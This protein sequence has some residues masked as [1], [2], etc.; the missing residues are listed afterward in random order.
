MI[1]ENESFMEKCIFLCVCMVIE[2]KIQNLISSLN[3]EFHGWVYIVPLHHRVIEIG[4]TRDQPWV[5]DDKNIENLNI[6]GNFESIIQI[7]NVLFC[8]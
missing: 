2:Q 1:Q 5:S 6:L 8:Y 7:W 3:L 4:M